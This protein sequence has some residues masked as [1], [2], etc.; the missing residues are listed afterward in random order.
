MQLACS[1]DAA[2]KLH[3]SSGAKNAPQD[4]KADDKRNQLRDRFYLFSFRSRRLLSQE[5]QERCV[6]LFGVSPG[7][8]VRTVFDHDQFR[9]F[10]HLRSALSC[11]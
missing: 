5:L 8:V 11:G 1:I 6:H 7:N 3:R 9:S 4:D 10:D 2:G